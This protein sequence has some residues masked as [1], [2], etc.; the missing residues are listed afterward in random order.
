[1]STSFA[2][3][4]IVACQALLSMGFPRQEHWS[5]LSSP[6]PVDLPDP[7]LEPTPSALTGGFFTTE[8][9]GKP[10]NSLYNCPMQLTPTR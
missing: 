7:G 2:A 5:V 1:M 8:P 10:C 9:L 6:P 3:P 4:W